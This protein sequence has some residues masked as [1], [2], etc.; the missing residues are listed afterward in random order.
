MIDFFK[1]F[2][3]LIPGYG[4]GDTWIPSERIVP[5]S[6][7]KSLRGL[8]AA[9][10][11]LLT[12]NQILP[13]QRHPKWGDGVDEKFHIYARE[14]AIVDTRGLD[15]EEA[16]NDFDSYLG[17]RVMWRGFIRGGTFDKFEGVL[18]QIGYFTAD[19]YGQGLFEIP[20]SYSEVTP[21]FNPLYDNVQFGNKDGSDFR[22]E[23][24]YF[25]RTGIGTEWNTTESIAVS[26]VGEYVWNRKEIIEKL[27]ADSGLIPVVDFPEGINDADYVWFNTIDVPEIGNYEGQSI[28]QALIDLLPEP[29]DFYFDYNDSSDY[30]RLQI[31]N[32][33]TVDVPLICPSAVATN[34]NIPLKET[35]TL[36]LTI[37]QQDIYD[38]VIVRGKPILWCGTVGLWGDWLNDDVLEPD[39][40][41]EE[42]TIW[43][44]AEIPEDPFAPDEIVANA[45]R[46]TLEN[47]YQ[48]FKWKDGKI[49]IGSRSGN[50]NEK[51]AISGMAGNYKNFFGSFTSIGMNDKADLNVKL[52][53]PYIFDSDNTPNKLAIE[54]EDFLPFTRVDP[55]TDQIQTNWE[56][57]R[58]ASPNVTGVVASIVPPGAGTQSYTDRSNHIL[59]VESTVELGFHKNGVWLR[60]MNPQTDLQRIPELFR[61]EVDGPVVYPPGPPFEI[62][63]APFLDLN[64]EEAEGSGW[65]SFWRFLIT[66]AGRSKQRLEA[67]KYRKD[68]NGD[69][70]QPSDKIKIIDVPAEVWLVHANTIRNLA[71]NKTK[72]DDS[73]NA[74]TDKGDSSRQIR[75]APVRF[76]F[77]E[78]YDKDLN[79]MGVHVVRDDTDLLLSYLESY[80]NLL[81]EVRGEMHLSLAID[82]TY[83]LNIGKLI[84]TVADGTIT[85]NVNSAVS[86]I[87]YILEGDTPLIEVHTQVPS[88]PLL[89]R[90]LDRASEGLGAVPPKKPLTTPPSLTTG[91]VIY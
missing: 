10:F 88:E 87:E 84:G 39:W 79:P 51:D 1:V 33:S 68:A 59:G 58:F 90:A 28:I 80:S 54:W 26:S 50:Y 47:V 25:S 12:D 18:D 14:I 16:K 9:H 82:R 61:T 4:G 86:S 67:F 77:E 3:K 73:P 2:I 6:F 40:T 36:N 20:I 89:T 13:S 64:P 60:R 27:C 24:I 81:M 85:Y 45:V 71:I 65:S 91:W 43:L 55:N 7:R 56:D 23:D 75:N 31:I 49:R 11:Q 29:F 15:D 76:L 62:S 74:F 83:D 70:V 53:K 42:E 19:E 37:K 57:D 38:R 46:E 48:K 35:E 52:K 32:K 8:G 72:K 34:Y 44:S 41:P 5:I 69:R 22:N 63:N 66:I 30:P 78:A 21:N 17:G